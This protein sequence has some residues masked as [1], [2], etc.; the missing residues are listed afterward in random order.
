MNTER[1]T[2]TTAGVWLSMY[3]MLYYTFTVCMLCVHERK[4]RIR[5]DHKIDT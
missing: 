2:A 5:Q 1:A 3:T 4:K